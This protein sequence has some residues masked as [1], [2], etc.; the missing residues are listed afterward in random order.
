MANKIKYNLKNVH[1]AVMTGG[2]VAS[3]GTATYGTPAPWD[4]A[5]SLSL[6]AEGGTNNF[7]ADGIVYYTSTKN[8]GYSGDF[9]SALVP[10][11]FRK[12]VLGDIE[13]GNGI[14]IENADAKPTHFALLF[15]FEGDAKGIYHCLYN[16]TANR[17]QVSGNTSED[18]IEP[19]TESL[20]ITATTIYDSTLKK[21]IVKARS[22]ENTA[23]SIE[24]D[25]FDAVPTP[26]APASA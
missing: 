17:P 23:S 13:D 26:T 24:E 20:T 11:A 22:G 21:N 7:Y 19:Q 25:W 18:T 16:C 5:V 12:N 4:G 8:N 2:D 10:E 15:Q 1:Y 3:D 9:E 14:L 6:D